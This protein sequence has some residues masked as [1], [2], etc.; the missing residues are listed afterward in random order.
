MLT[1]SWMCPAW[2]SS[3]VLTSNSWM[4]RT[5]NMVFS[6]QYVTTEAGDMTTTKSTFFK[7][8]TVFTEMCG[9]TA[10]HHPLVVNLFISLLQQVVR[11]NWSFHLTQPLTGPLFSVTNQ[12]ARVY[13]TLCF[14]QSHGKPWIKRLLSIHCE[15][16]GRRCSTC[17]FNKATE[18]FKS[19]INSC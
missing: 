15:D 18:H 8:K 7:F 10:T 13:Q 9:T 11:V 1:A 5:D 12:N 17:C 14:W 19:N 4:S 16:T 6:C 3:G 2:Y